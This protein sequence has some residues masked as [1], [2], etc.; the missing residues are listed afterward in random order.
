M[1]HTPGPWRIGP[2]N[3]AD[4]DNHKWADGG[5]G[6]QTIAANKPGSLFTR[7]APGVNPKCAEPGSADF[8]HREQSPGAATLRPR[9]PH[10]GASARRRSSRS[11]TSWMTR[12]KHTLFGVT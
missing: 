9:R 4:D 2:I 6:N 11:P 12:G 5:P 10:G 8:G 3:Y 1:K 7:R